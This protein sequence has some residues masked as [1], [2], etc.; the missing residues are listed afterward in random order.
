MDSKK[1]F[2]NDISWYV[3]KKFL[4]KINL[5]NRSWYVIKKFLIPEQQIFNTIYGQLG[6]EQR[7]YYYSLVS[8]RLLIG[9]I[10]EL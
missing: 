3:I 1:I 7:D 8:H 4:L 6:R 9:M 10:N 5:S 2:F